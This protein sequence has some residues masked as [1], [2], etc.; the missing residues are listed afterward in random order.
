[1]PPKHKHEWVGSH[2][3]EQSGTARYVLLPCR[4][5]EDCSV[6]QEDL[7]SPSPS[8]LCPSRPPPTARRCCRCY[9]R[10]F[11][12]VATTAATAATQHSPSLQLR[13]SSG[14]RAPVARALSPLVAFRAVRCCPLAVRRRRG[15]ARSIRCRHRRAECAVEATAESLLTTSPHLTP[16]LAASPLAPPHPPEIFSKQDFTGSSAQKIHIN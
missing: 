1:M 13:L 3:A 15:A 2:T 8:Q 14:L 16:P 9:R 10:T 6:T 4:F 7:S 11:H 5:D 12:A